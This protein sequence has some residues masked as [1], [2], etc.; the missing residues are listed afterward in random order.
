M[1]D[2]S[3]SYFKSKKI[4]YS[5]V[6]TTPLTEIEKGASKIE[7]KIF[8]QNDNDISHNEKDEEWMNLKTPSI[9][10]LFIGTFIY[11]DIRFHQNLR[12]F[13]DHIYLKWGNILYWF[14]DVDDEKVNKIWRKII[15]RS[16][17]D[18]HT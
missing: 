18:F 4:T 10:R 6:V 8:D 11:T 1:F 7:E 3:Y 9:S 17:E 15:L 16:K 5:V 2:N 14:S 12:L 13:Y